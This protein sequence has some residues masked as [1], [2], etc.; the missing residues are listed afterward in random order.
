M[1]ALGG[2]REDECTAVLSCR[3][4]RFESRRDSVDGAAGG[5][6]PVK[7][8]ERCNCEHEYEEGKSNHR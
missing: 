6:N 2:A 4:G 7:E 8:E 3:S 1:T 5:P